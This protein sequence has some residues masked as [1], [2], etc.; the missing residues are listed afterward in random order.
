VSVLLLIAMRTRSE[1]YH[2]AFAIF[3]VVY[4]IAYPWFSFDTV[5]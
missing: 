4:L 3:T 2:A 1:R 5:G